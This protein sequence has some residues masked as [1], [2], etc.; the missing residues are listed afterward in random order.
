MYVYLYKL[1]VYKVY[2]LIIRNRKLIFIYSMF[3]FI[4]YF[5]YNCKMKNEKELCMW[6]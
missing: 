5:K 1:N 2:I 6:V 3:K 4:I